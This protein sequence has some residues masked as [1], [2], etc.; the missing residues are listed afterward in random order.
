MR[1][2][3]LIDYA[4]DLVGD[5]AGDIQTDEKSL[6]YL[7]RVLRDI[8]SRSRTIVEPLYLPSREG[9][10][11]YGLPDGFL[12]CDIAAWLQPDGRYRPLEPIT[13]DVASWAIH[14]KITGRPRYFDTFG[15]AAVE[16]AVETVAS[17]DAQANAFTW[18]LGEWIDIKVRDRV[19]NVS[20]GSSTAFVAWFRNDLDDAGS[21]RQT[22]GYTPLEG[23]TRKVL[24][25]GDQVRI[26]S[27][28]ANLHA[29]V[30]SPVPVDVGDI[31]HEALFL[32]VARAHRTITAVDVGNENDDIELDIEFERAVIEFLA[33]DMRRDELGLQSAETQAQR[34]VAETAYR[35][36]LPDVL[37]RIR[38][39]KISWRRSQGLPLQPTLNAPVRVRYPVGVGSDG[40]VR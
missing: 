20:D 17:V 33:A 32:W 4:R 18:N 22:I 24:Q 3:A 28:G 30:I 23:G 26:L 5:P 9:Q 1:A 38:A 10:S 37:K 36:A 34:V 6:R 15:R 35:E 31:G 11:I 13:M 12:R 16:R 2:A 14:N 8:S 21:R 27:P 19:I 25:A 29:L 7:N 40:E 39:W